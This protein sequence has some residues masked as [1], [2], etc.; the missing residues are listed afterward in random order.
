MGNSTAAVIA[1]REWINQANCKDTDPA[2][3]YVGGKGNEDGR[4]PKERIRI[5]LAACADCV[6]LHQCREYGIK[7]EQYGIWGGMTE[8]DRR[9]ERKARGIDIE[10]ITSHGFWGQL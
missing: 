2:D 9:R 1:T 3:F 5:A 8:M 4:R 6:V 10:P 7:H